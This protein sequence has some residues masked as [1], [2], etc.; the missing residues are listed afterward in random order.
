MYI[1]IPIRQAM[2]AHLE[3]CLPEEGCGLLGGKQDL[4][5]RVWAISNLLHSPNGFRMDPQAQ[6][7]AFIQME[8]LGIDL[9]GIYHSHPHGP[10]APSASDVAEFAY[11]G[12]ISLICVPANGE[13]IVRGFEIRNDQVLEINLS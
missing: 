4:C 5:Q 9:I 12:V 3:T 7:Q 8:E 11:P 13:W 1:P 2:L 10:Q 6:L